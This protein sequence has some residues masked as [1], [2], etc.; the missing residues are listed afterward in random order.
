[1]ALAGSDLRPPLLT[2]LIARIQR[3]RDAR[4]MDPAFQ[5][6][7]A[8]NPLTRP[9]VNAKGRQLYDIVAGFV[10]SQILSAA[11]ELDLFARLQRGP[12]SAA[13]L[14]METGVPEEGMERLCQGAAA[15]GLLRRAS[16]ET[17]ALGQLGAVLLGAPGVVEMVR[18][19]RL[20]YADLA[21]PVALLKG[22]MPETELS[23]FWAYVHG[24]AAGETAGAYSALMAESQA[25]VAVETLATG[26]LKDARVLLDIGGGEGAFLTAALRA[27]PSLSGIVF[28]LPPVAERAGKAI[29]EGGFSERAS[30]VGGSFRT[31][32]LPEGADAVS[33]IRVLYDHPD[34]VVADLLAK[35]F[36]YLPSGGRLV[37]SEPMS[38]GRRPTRE[39]DA[40]FGLY[41]AAMTSGKPRSMESH[42]KALA[43]AGFSAIRPLRARQGFITRVIL[44]DKT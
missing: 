4:I 44:A 31:D 38:G 35:V 39:G 6:W 26:A 7:A 17:F 8:R 9:L 14:S 10:Y 21:D 23:T 2:R 29:A 13:V 40:Y 32:A 41:T 43:R 1:M 36:A 3:W 15:L 34:E 37:I 33:L 19:H 24:R 28:D 27:H 25:M 22:E 11:V 20:L 12:K 5:A 18:H 16:S 42:S 30:A